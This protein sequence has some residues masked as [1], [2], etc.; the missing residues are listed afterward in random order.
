[1]FKSKKNFII[2]LVGIIFVVFTTNSALKNNKKIEFPYEFEF[3]N[4]KVEIEYAKLYD[5]Y[6]LTKH[7]ISKKDGSI[8]QEDDIN[9]TTTISEN[10]ARG[11]MIGPQVISTRVIDNRVKEEI[12]TFFIAETEKPIK[13]ANIRHSLILKGN[14][15]INSI[16]TDGSV[17]LTNDDYNYI[18]KKFKIDNIDLTVMSLGNFEFGG[19][20]HI[21]TENLESEEL[22]NLEKNYFIRLKSG[23]FQEDFK[24][25][26]IMGY[27]E[28]IVKKI[29]NFGDF[30]PN[31]K[32]T[33]FF[34]VNMLY[35]TSK[36]DNDNIEIYIVNKNSNEETRII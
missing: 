4:Y 6:L 14:I 8:T 16:K 21:F 12:S 34:G 32:L 5:N 23:E 22:Q 1:M 29:S 33:E 24:I 27:K 28:E 31:S 18:N 36:V 9:I 13:K 7:N 11:Y 20:L 30:N 2:F 25:N 3:E 17:F 19:L 10:T 35:D 15:D 26:T